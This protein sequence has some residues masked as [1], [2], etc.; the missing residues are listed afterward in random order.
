MTK[1]RRSNPRVDV[2]HPVLYLTNICPS[3]RL[4]R[5]IDLS[6]GG[7]GIET[8]HCLVDGQALELSIAI[9][10]RVIYCSGQVVYILLGDGKP[11]AGIRFKN[12]SQRDRR[13]LEE[14]ISL[15][16]EPQRN[17]GND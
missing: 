9:H 3:P 16:M 13:H 4:A 17:V 7:A 14:H 6:M 10:P 12:M 2:S 11:M 5:T 15:L 8:P 1:E